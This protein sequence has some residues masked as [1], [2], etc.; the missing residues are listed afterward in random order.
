MGFLAQLDLS[1]AQQG[2]VDQLRKDMDE[3]MAP[4]Y[5]QLDKIR[6]QIHALWTAQVPDQKKILATMK[7]LDP[8]KEKIRAAHVGLKLQVI[9]LLTPAQNQER[10]QMMAR[11]EKRRQRGERRGPKGPGPD[12]DLD[13]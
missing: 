8:L 10:L 11:F 6:D 4:V 5:A 2:Q 1:D 9:A 7:Q 3:D 13:L 12:G